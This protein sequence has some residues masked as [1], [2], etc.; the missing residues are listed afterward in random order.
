M[1]TI[2]INVTDIVTNGHADNLTLAIPRFALTG[3]EYIARQKRSIF[4]EVL[5]Q[6]WQLFTS[7]RP[8]Q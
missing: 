7:R 6:T 1:V 4:D 2:Y 3:L 8:R 5:T